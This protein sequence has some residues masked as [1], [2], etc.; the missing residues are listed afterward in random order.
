[1]NSLSTLKLEF[2]PLHPSDIPFIYTWLLQPH[3]AEWW[4]CSGSYAEIAEDFLPLTEATSSTRAYLAWLADEPI[5][6]IQVYVV[7]DSGDGWW[8][9]ETDPGARG[10]D[11][12]LGKAQQLNQGLG[13]EM[14]KA[15]TEFLFQDSAVTKIQ[16]D[17]APDNVRAIRCYTKAGFKSI[18]QVATPDGLALLMVKQRLV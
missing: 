14:V 2:R 17:P 13:T 7:K 12:F 11:Q 9:E 4:G 3:V 16:T 18:K 1:M 8:E 6:F 10:I 5:G 15:F